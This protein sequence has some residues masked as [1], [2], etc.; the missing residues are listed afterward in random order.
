MS[1]ITPVIF[2]GSDTV[3]SQVALMP[4]RLAVTTAVPIPHPVTTP[5]SETVATEGFEDVQVREPV[6]FAVEGS[7]VAERTT[8]PSTMI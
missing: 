1:A 3:T 2:T 8:V 4:S 7:F 5:V 6:V